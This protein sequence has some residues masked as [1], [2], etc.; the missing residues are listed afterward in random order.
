MRG[1]ADEK[2]EVFLSKTSKLIGD[3]EVKADDKVIKSN[4]DIVTFDSNE[5]ED[6]T[7]KTY[8]RELKTPFEVTLEDEGDYEIPTDLKNL[9]LEGLEEINLDDET[10]FN[11]TN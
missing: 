9:D 2:C 11:L 5:S 7:K 4:K 6:D 3:K 10:L 1:I 8:T